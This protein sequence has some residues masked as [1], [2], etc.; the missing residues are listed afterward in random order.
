MRQRKVGLDPPTLPDTTMQ[1]RSFALTALLLLLM[2]LMAPFVL[3]AV[4]FGQ[5]G[6]RDTLPNS[7]YLQS[8]NAAANLG[9]FAHML[10][11]GVITL[12]VP[13]QLIGPLR[14]RVPALHRISGRI[15][16]AAAIVTAVGGLAYIALRG[17]IGGWPMDLGFSLYGAL[18]L[19]AATQTYR[20]ARARRLDQHHAWALRFFW[21]AIGSWLYRAHYGLWYAATD[22]LWSLRDFSGPF[23]LV[24]NFA[25]YLPYLIGVEIY[26]RQTRFTPAADTESR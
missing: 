10:A 4:N 13:L 6:L 15:I 20:H 16:A 21:L 8:N 7:H 23:D 18:T 22:G 9:I 14:Q 24:Q 26:L 25:F 11:G 2:L 5:G 17:T 1:L 12:L 3:Y 19:L